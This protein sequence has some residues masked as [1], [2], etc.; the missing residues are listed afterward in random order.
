MIMLLPTGQKCVPCLVASA[1]VLHMLHRQPIYSV[2]FLS[3][4]TISWWLLQRWWAHA[5]ATSSYCMKHRWNTYRGTNCLEVYKANPASWHWILCHVVSLIVFSTPKCSWWLTKFFCRIMLQ[6]N[7]ATLQSYGNVLHC[8][9]SLGCKLS[10]G[11]VSG[12]EDKDGFWWAR[13]TGPN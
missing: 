5:C 3:S 6:G 13:D 1:S 10:C 12:D 4:A 8:F 11:M 9:G 7:Q 2:H